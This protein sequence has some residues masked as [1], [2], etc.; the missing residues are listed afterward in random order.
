MMAR[1]EIDFQADMIKH[2]DLKSG[3]PRAHRIRKTRRIVAKV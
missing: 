2:V 1:V 3:I